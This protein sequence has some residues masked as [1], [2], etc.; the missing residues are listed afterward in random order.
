[1]AKPQ[2]RPVLTQPEDQSIRLIPLT[3]GQVAIVDATD[4][5]W[6]NQ[7]AWHS[8]W[9]EQN[10]AFYAVRKTSVN[11]KRPVVRMHRQIMGIEPYDKRIVDH[12]KIGDTLNNRRSNLRIATHS[13]NHANAS[14]RRDNTTGYKGL[15]WIE[16]RGHYIS[17][18][19]ID[20]KIKYLGQFGLDKVAAARAYDA[21][22]AAAPSQPV[23]IS[24]ATGETLDHNCPPIAPNWTVSADRLVAAATGTPVAT[25][26]QIHDQTTP[27]TPVEAGCATT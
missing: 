13:L 24:P 22:T 4:Y 3:K 9:H 10:Q 27:R 17:Q 6:I 7:W 5:D 19:T 23:Y 15:I 21:A 12:K 25:T 20:G 14:I 1:M 16:R 8:E 11:G 2:Q 18:I 26:N